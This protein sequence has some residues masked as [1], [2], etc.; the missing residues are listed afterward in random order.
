ME[1]GADYDVLLSA[2]GRHISIAVS[3]GQEHDVENIRL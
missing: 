2:I 1:E 3:L